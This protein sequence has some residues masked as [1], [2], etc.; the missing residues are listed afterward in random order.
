M[1]TYFRAA[2]ALAILGVL[3][4][5]AAQMAPPYFHNLEFQRF[6]ETASAESNTQA[7]EEDA[8][9]AAALNKAALLGLPVRFDNVKVTPAGEHFAIQVNYVVRVDLPLYTVDLHFRPSAGAK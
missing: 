4:L 7:Q 3:A 9:R 6:L 5:L 8:V 1:A 2:V